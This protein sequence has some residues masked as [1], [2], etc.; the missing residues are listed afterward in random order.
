MT[1]GR[2]LLLLAVFVLLARCQQKPEVSMSPRLLQIFTGDIF[3][4][5]CDNNT[6]GS[7]VKWYIDD[8]EQTQ[9]N[10]TW[11]I[12]VAAPKH[13]GSYK[14]ES[15]GL[16]SDAFPIVVLEYI[17]R[18]SLIMKTGQPVMRNGGSVI[19]QLDNDDGLQG[20]N[21]W[22]YRG[23]GRT[24]ERRIKLR[25]KNDSVSLDFQPT[26]LM[27]P[28]T[29]FWCSDSTQQHRSNQVMVR[30]SEKEVSL[31]MYPFPAVAGENLIL[32]CLVWGTDQITYTL[33]YKDN[34]I[35]Q[36]STNPSIKISDVTEVT[37]GLYKCDA[38]FT[39]KARTEG[40]P[41]KVASDAQDLF[42]QAVPMKAFLSENVGLSCSCPQCP[43]DGF[44]RWYK[45]SDDGQPVWLTDSSTGF[46]MMKESG[47]YACRAVWKQG[48]SS[49]SNSFVYQPPIKTILITVVIVLVILGLAITAAAY[50]LWYKKRNVTGP[51]YEDVALKSQ[52][53]GDDKYESLQQPRGAQREAEYDTLRPEATDSGKKDNNYEPLKKGEMKEGVYHTL[54]MEGAAGG[55]GGYEA[56]RKEEMKAEVY[57]TLGMEGAAG[58]AG[59]YEALRK[60]GMK[61]GVYHT[62]GMEGAAGGAGGYEALRKEGMKEG[63]YHTLGMEGAGDL[64]KIVEEKM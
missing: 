60:E 14:C 29:I 38:T 61:E 1:G 15:N 40:Q 34:E 13:S 50:F 30:T 4:L 19:L 6:G 59:G 16:K 35:I 10:K 54:G 18:A 45:N 21:C 9:T 27:V 62:L 2:H 26:R 58:G 46:M 49:L 51:I 56:L 12:A 25:L 24:G 5:N 3:Y 22:V 42:V 23:Q 53:K 33:F 43:S 11:K 37:E 63:V 7:R 64:D 28:E 32:R 44:Y 47:S 52:D 41:Y 8:N 39:Y 17:P 55:A 57:H 36:G 48:M 31:E 20:W